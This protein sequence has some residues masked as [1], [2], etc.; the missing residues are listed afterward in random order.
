MDVFSDLDLQILR[1][2]SSI[3]SLPQPGEDTRSLS[4]N[5][6]FTV[7]DHSQYWCSPLRDRA[8]AFQFSLWT[9]D[10]ASLEH[11]RRSTSKLSRCQSTSIALYL[12][13]PHIEYDK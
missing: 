11:N 9:R 13:F 7:L 5:V 4:I 2:V 10:E 6:D 8:N 12:D 1:S 3:L